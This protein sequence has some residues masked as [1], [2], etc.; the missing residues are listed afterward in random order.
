MIQTGGLQVLQD[1]VMEGDVQGDGCG[2]SIWSAW[3]A[4]TPLYVPRN[5][6]SRIPGLVGS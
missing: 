3:D 4:N 5:T 2:W 1:K 6:P